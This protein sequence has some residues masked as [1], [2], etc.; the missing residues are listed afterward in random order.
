VDV[1]VAAAAGDNAVVVVDALLQRRRAEQRIGERERSDGARNEHAE[2]G[3]P[4]HTLKTHSRQCRVHSTRPSVAAPL[5]PATS[6]I[7]I[8]IIIV[9]MVEETRRE[10][11][12][13]GGI[14]SATARHVE[15][16]ESEGIA[17]RQQR[18][19]VLLAGRT[20]KARHARR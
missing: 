11:T 8:I 3:A 7:L 6:T 1:A 17:N 16:R 2:H 14:G 5:L 18:I 9:I 13:Q 20:S 19:G 4:R 15:R 10:G 12:Q